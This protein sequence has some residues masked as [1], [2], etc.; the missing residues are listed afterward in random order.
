VILGRF[1]TACAT[2]F[3]AGLA[4]NVMNLMLIATAHLR[5]ARKGAE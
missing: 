1:H 3:L 5:Q 2:A 4:F